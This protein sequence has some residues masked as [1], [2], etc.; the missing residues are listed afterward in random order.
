MT[1][2][3]DGIVHSAFIVKKDVHTMYLLESL[4][5]QDYI[6]TYEHSPYIRTML[7]YEVSTYICKYTL[8]LG[9]SYTQ[10]RVWKVSEI[11]GEGWGRKYLPPPSSIQ[12]SYSKQ[13]KEIIFPPCQVKVFTIIPCIKTKFKLVQFNLKD[14]LKLFITSSMLKNKIFFEIFTPARIVN[15]LLTVAI[16]TIKA[17]CDKYTYI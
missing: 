11:G 6:F 17:Y 15:S 5:L 12:Q 7:T 1:M 10:Q 16:I 8:Y 13:N 14:N 9:T 2:K 3:T 4:C